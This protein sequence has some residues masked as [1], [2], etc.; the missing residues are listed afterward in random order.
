M[1]N[2]GEGASAGTADP[3]VAAEEPAG[4]PGGAKGASYFFKDPTLEFNF[5]I[6][7]GGAYYQGADVGKVLWLT[8]QIPDGDHEAAYQALK[9]AGDEAMAIADASAARGPSRKRAP[10]L[11]LG[12]GLLRRHGLCRRRLCGFVPRARRL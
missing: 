2:S 6:A 8:R 1:A 4:P 7:L 9:A 10:S 12:A 11:F 5:L 3:A